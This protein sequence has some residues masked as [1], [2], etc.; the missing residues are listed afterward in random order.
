MHPWTSLGRLQ[1]SWD[2]LLAGERE[3]F[4]E[5]GLRKPVK[6]D[7]HSLTR[8]PAS[9]PSAARFL[10]RLAKP[11]RGTRE[12]VVARVRTETSPSGGVSR[13]RPTPQLDPDLNAG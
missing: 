6:G 12:M 11:K 10:E 5:S 4:A 7:F 8:T 13:G 9:I 2:D 1:A 3:T